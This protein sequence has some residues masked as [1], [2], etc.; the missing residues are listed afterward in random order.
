[1]RKYL[2]IAALLVMVSVFL[3]ACGLSDAE[4]K[5]NSGTD[6]LNKNDLDGALTDLNEAIRL[7]PNLAVAYMNRGALYLNKGDNDKAIEDSTKAIDLKLARVEDQATN[8]SNRSAAY[9]NKS[10][11]G[12]ALADAEEAIKIK[13]DFGFAYFA[14]G[15]ARAQMSPQDKEGAIAD[16]KKVIELA[17]DSPQA[18][19][20]QQNIDLL[21][22][23][24]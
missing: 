21:Q 11:F 12:N 9:S 3:T 7:D 19:Q 4:Q 13:S 17:K 16:F 18:K 14:R 20:A 10:D 24:P 5:Y 23:A 2:S 1:M 6:K 22:A 15:I 8:L